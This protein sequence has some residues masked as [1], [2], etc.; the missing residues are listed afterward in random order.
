MNLWVKHPRSAQP[1]AML[2]L[3]TWALAV[4][5]FRFLFSNVSIGTLSF[6]QLDS[7]VVAAILTPTLGAYCFRKMSDSPDK[8]TS[9]KAE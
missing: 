6:G 2:T 1:D 5:L 7:T 9:Q 4:V 3:G 8:P